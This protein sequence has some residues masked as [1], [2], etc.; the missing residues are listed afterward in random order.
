MFLQTIIEIGLL[1]CSPVMKSKD[2]NRQFLQI[3]VQQIKCNF[4]LITSEYIT[5]KFVILA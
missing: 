5:I 4:E 2:F 3:S 1:H